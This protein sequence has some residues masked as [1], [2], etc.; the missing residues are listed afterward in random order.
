MDKKCSKCK[1]YL[2][3]EDFGKSSGGNYLRPECLPCNNEL[4]RVRKALKKEHGDPPLDHRC[5]ICLKDEHGVE[6][7]G[8]NAGPWVIDHDHTTGAF[9]GW[10]CHKCNRAL[11]GFEDD[12]STL[13]AAIIYLGGYDVS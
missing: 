2:P 7:Y 3:L 1:Q 9:R 13:A 12:I 4:K 5:P 11:G 10:L 6:G 8:G